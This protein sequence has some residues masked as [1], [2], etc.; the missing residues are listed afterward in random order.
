MN[1][2]FLPDVTLATAKPAL[3]SARAVSIAK[4]LLPAGGLVHAPRLEIYAG[5]AS[6]ESGPNARLAWFVWLAAGPQN[7]SN[8]YVVD[9]TTGSILHVF[10]RAFYSETPDVEIDNAEN[11]IKLPGEKARWQGEGVTEPKEVDNAYEDLEEAFEFYRKIKREPRWFGYNE[12]GTEPELATVDYGA[13]GCEASEWYSALQEIYLCEGFAKAPDVVGHEYAGAVIEHSE[14]EVGE[15]QAGAIA[16]G[17]GDAMGE[18][19]ESYK[20]T[21]KKKRKNRH[22]NGSTA[23]KPQVALS[24]ISRNQMIEKLEVEGK[25]YHDPEKLS[26]YLVA[27]IDGE[28]FHENSTII[29]HAFYLLAT[30]T[31]VATAANIF[32]DMQAAELKGQRHPELEQAEKAAVAAAKALY[33]AENPEELSTQAKDTQSA[34]EAVELNGVKPM[35]T[36]PSIGCTKICTFQDALTEQEPAHGTAST[37]T[38]LATLYKARG[39]LAHNSAAGRHF[40]PLYEQNMGRIT[41]LV[42]RDPTLEETA[43]NG[44]EEIGPALNALAEGNGQKYKLSAVEMT[45]IEAALKRLAQDDRLISGGG[46]LAAMIERELKWLHLSSYA[47]M[48]YAEG[49]RAAERRSETADVGHARR[50]QLQ[51]HTIP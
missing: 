7:A 2:S 4:A 19:L 42:S 6:Q 17:F 39:A 23:S 24:A 16:E 20:K 41:E 50:P 5:P 12:Q 25:K 32:F 44:L 10:V 30:K 48:T 49:L 22:R 13:K 31:T 43:V 9:A 51:R 3:S 45:K 36:S 35:P 37:L 34:F 14:G 11:K 8:E 15:G 40:M 46:T 18:A 1:G 21:S 47:G 27:C 26:E 29:S 28:A 33:P 38:M